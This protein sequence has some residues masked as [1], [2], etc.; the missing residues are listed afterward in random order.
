MSDKFLHYQIHN[1]PTID[2]SAAIDIISQPSP[3][4]YGLSGYFRRGTVF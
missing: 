1:R 4:N 2:D 3:L